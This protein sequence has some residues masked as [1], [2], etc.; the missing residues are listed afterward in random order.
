MKRTLIIMCLFFAT[1]S[2]ADDEGFPIQLTCELGHLIVY[3]NITDN[4][5]TTWWQNHSSNRGPLDNTGATQLFELGNRNEKGIDGKN[6]VRGLRAK[7]E[8]NTNSIYIFTLE[9]RGVVTFKINRLTGGFTMRISQGLESSGHCT[10][11]FK[12]YEKNVF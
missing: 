8:V 1:N 6:Q 11:G 4:P 5:E 10:K 12:N 7:L 2:W 3:L 9:G